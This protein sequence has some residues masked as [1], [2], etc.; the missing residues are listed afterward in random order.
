VNIFVFPIELKRPAPVTNN[1]NTPRKK[2]N[3]P[4]T[5]S[6]TF[7]QIAIIPV[8]RNDQNKKLITESKMRCLIRNSGV[9][10]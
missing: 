10:W 7:L 3:L 8:K 2:K 9:S 6:P 4:Q 5:V 1:I